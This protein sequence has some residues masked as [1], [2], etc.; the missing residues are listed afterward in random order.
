MRYCYLQLDENTYNYNE[1]EMH[2]ISNSAARTDLATIMDRVCDDRDA[3][4]ITR[5]GGRP[6]VML[7]L[8]DYNSIEATAYLTRSPANDL[9]LTKSIN[10]I[11]LDTMRD[12]F[13]G[14]GKPDALKHEFAGLWSRRIT[15][16]HRM[17]YHVEAESLFCVQLRF[18]S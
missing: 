4:I 10:R 6:V 1:F 17:V 15:A 5:N 18:Q 7:S 16:E 2:A 9:R 12:P 11:I 13:D 14:T 3:M 8:E